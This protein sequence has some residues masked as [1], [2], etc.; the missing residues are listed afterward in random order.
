MGSVKDKP[1]D[2]AE[3]HKVFELE[4]YERELG[5]PIT[6]VAFNKNGTL[7]AFAYG[8]KI[9]LYNNKFNAIKPELH[10][11][12]L[13][14]HKEGF[15]VTSLSFHPILPFLL[16]G[17]EDSTAKLWRISEGPAICIATT[18]LHQQQ[19]NTD[20]PDGAVN[21]HGV[22]RS[23]NTPSPVL[24]VSFHPI[25]P[26]FITG[27]VS[28][29]HVRLWRFDPY[30]KQHSVI[31]PAVV[32]SNSS[33]RHDVYC[34]A[35]H[36]VKPFLA[37][38]SGKYAK[39]WND[40]LQEEPIIME[41]PAAV[42]CL[43]FHP[44]PAAMVLATG[45]N[46]KL[47]RVWRFSPDNPKKD[48]AATYVATLAGHSGY[49]SS[50]AFH[51]NQDPMKSILAT[52]SLDK[53]IKLWHLSPSFDEASCIT[54]LNEKDRDSILT[55]RNFTSFAFDPNTQSP[56]FHLVTGSS[57]GN[58][59]LWNVNEKI[60]QTNAYLMRRELSNG[61]KPTTV[62]AFT[63]S[64]KKSKNSKSHRLPTHFKL[65]KGGKRRTPRNNRPHTRRRN[66]KP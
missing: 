62:A 60:A 24:S 20:L 1:S 55:K 9:R 10:Y 64:N 46:D 25:H 28:D 65:N 42:R 66:C 26:T 35:F 17:S 16:T 4:M 52:C 41:H 3:Y 57:I 22:L 48:E 56:S 54:T 44:N 32:L 2:Y 27:A 5:I 39:L 37:S 14:R 49:I 23:R 19:V 45:S 61:A 43:A 33:A 51:P 36:P 13:L 11:I 7:L 58:V 30:Q 59:D 12:D 40:N 53:T 6:S 18:Q 29:T 8:N 38:C 21:S 47:V 34:V 50:L 31:E 15:A 63:S